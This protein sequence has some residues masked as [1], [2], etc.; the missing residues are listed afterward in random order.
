MEILI[1][2]DD[3]EESLEEVNLKVVFLHPFGNAR[4]TGLLV[5]MRDIICMDEATEMDN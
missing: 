1:D 3:Q 5:G 2:R 4:V